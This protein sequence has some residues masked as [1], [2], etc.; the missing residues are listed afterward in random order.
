MKKEENS[1]I[2]FN[3][4]SIIYKLEDTLIQLNRHS[5]FLE[6]EKFRELTKSYLFCIFTTSPKLGEFNKLLL[7]NVLASL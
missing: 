5:H 4:L 2:N 6:N 1:L 7:Y 3:D